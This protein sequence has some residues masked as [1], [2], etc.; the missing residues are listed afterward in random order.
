MCVFVVMLPRVIPITLKICAKI[1]TTH[2]FTALV[3]TIA[4]CKWRVQTISIGSAKR[5]VN[6]QKEKLLAT[7]L[8]FSSSL[9]ALR[10]INLST[11]PIIAVPKDSSTVES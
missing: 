6:A 3:F 4:T 7:V 9:R 2:H 8:Q 5:S 1:L 10:Y 11:P